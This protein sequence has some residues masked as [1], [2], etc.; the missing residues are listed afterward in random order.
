[1]AIHETHHS[2]ISLKFRFYFEQSLHNLNETF[3]VTINQFEIDL[4]ESSRQ[5]K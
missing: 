2:N 5:H 1:M 4:H 3:C